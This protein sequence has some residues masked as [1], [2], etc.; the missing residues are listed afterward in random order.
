M[1]WEGQLHPS[2]EKFGKRRGGGFSGQRDLIKTQWVYYH[3][4]KGKDLVSEVLRLLQSL[5]LSGFTVI[6]VVQQL[7]VFLLVSYTSREPQ[8]NSQLNRTQTLNPRKGAENS[9]FVLDSSPFQ[10]LHVRPTGKGRVSQVRVTFTE[11]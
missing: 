4:Q 8:K 10:K 3:L 11:P 2:N 5:F 6:N 9:R 1:Y 7:G